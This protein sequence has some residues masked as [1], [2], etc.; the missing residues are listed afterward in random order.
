MATLEEKPFRSEKESGKEPGQVYIR[1]GHPQ[2][3]AHVVPAAGKTGD[4]TKGDF[5][6]SFLVG[7][8]LRPRRPRTAAESP[9]RYPVGPRL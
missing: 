6:T 8:S 5:I 7:G 2:V 4:L 9:L 1:M 3:R